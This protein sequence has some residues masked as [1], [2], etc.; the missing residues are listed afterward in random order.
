MDQRLQQ[1]ARTVANAPGQEEIVQYQQVGVEPGTQLPLLIGTATQ[2]VIRKDT[3]G[4]EY[5][6]IQALQRRLV[7]NRLG[8]PAFARAGFADDQ[9]V[10]AFSDEFQRMQLEARLARQLRIEAPVKVRQGRTLVQTRLLVT[11]VQQTR[12]AAVQF[13]LQNH[14]ESLQER[15]LV[16]L[17]LQY[18]SLQGGANAGQAQVAQRTFDFVHGHAHLESSRGSDK[19]ALLRA[20]RENRSA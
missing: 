8:D 3:V 12:T 9:R 1:L 6:H 4:F 10:L 14:R 2:P 19:A 15:R 5:P 16:C 11:T 18:A 13:I 7:G 17:R 20:P